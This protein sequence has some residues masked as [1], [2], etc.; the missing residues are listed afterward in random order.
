MATLEKIR[1]KSVLLFT[2]I[3]VAL[4][5]FILGDFFTSGRSLFGPGDTVAKANGA[6]VNL[7]DY[8]A[9]TNEYNDLVKNNNQ[10]VNPDQINQ[11][12]IM[13]LMRDALL[14]EE[15]DRLGIVVTDKQLQNFMF[16][17]TTS[18]QVLQMI[19]QNI[20]VQP[21]MFMQMGLTTP[22]AIY[23]AI[24]NPQKYGMSAQDAKIFQDAWIA[25]EKDI[26]ENI[27]LGNYMNLLGGLFTAN[28]VDAKNTYND[29]NTTSNFTF[30]AKDYMSIPDDKVKLS[31]ADYEA[32]YNDHKGSF[33]LE[34]EKRYISYIAVSMI[35]SEADR[36]K[37]E[38]D[39]QNLIAAL[40]NDTTD[41]NEAVRKFHGFTTKS[42]KYTRAMLAQDNDLRSLS[43]TADSLRSG[44]VKQL[45]T[46]G[47]HYAVAK[48]NGIT[49]GIDTVKF[50]VIP[51]ENV[52]KLDS[53][54][55]TVTTENID[56][57]AGPMASQQMSL[58]R[59]E[60]Q[61]TDNMLSQFAAAP[62]NQIVTVT[63]SVDTANGKEAVAMI[64]NVKSRSAAVPVYNVSTV[65]YDLSPSDAT[66]KDVTQ[67]LRNYVANN[68]TA[69]A[70]SKNAAKAGYTVYHALVSPSDPIGDN[71]P[72]SMGVVK[73]VMN[74][75]EGKV[76]KVYSLTRP[77]AIN[78]SNQYLLAVALEEVYDDDFIP[79]N[80]AYVKEVTKPYVT[81]LKKAQMTIDQYK[82]KAKTL[83]EY[84]KL[85]G[86]QVSNASSA[87]GEST[88]TGIMATSPELQAAIATA[89]PGTLVGPVRGQGAIYFIK[90]SDSKT[91]GRPYN[92]TEN[93]QNYL[94][95][96][97]MNFIDQTVNGYRPS[98]RMLIG[99]NKVTNNLL[100]FTAEAE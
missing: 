27:K 65:T 99:D 41:N 44:E 52:S 80:S 90:V 21:Q 26:E 74:A 62:L 38:T 20:G 43:F 17:E 5:A 61:L 71:A 8:Q 47:T 75:D 22:R 6:K 29:R 89:K 86:T 98:L 87:F 92:Y 64:V 100:E 76:S 14:A 12:A 1:S 94:Q 24:K 25:A 49:T 40:Q 56:S 34:Q 85:F 83:E 30:V 93:A 84:A 57:L 81:D 78:G 33:K 60:F 77:A 68:S 7:N 19:A 96:T 23:D 59:N 55:A 16:G 91:Q 72:G 46:N 36:K 37:V 9:R 58:I 53:V 42:A 67:Q 10:S 73:W 4:L 88:I 45:P 79:A 69:E 13:D 70:F 95:R 3:I 48:V 63:D 11:T 35:P 31:D 15:Y 18:P 97:Q 39:V 51:V 54:L 66:L 50:S 32:F 2:I 28:A 82:G